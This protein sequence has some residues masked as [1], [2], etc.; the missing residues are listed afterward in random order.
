MSSQRHAPTLSFVIPV[1]NDEAR[2]RRCLESIR[3]DPAFSEL[4]EA[5]VVDNGS[6][7]GSAVMA[8]NMGAMVLTRPGLRVSALRNDGAAAARGEFLA[9]VDADHELLAG[10]IGAVIEDLA[11][12]GVG[13]V[14]AP[15][16]AVR[17]GT[18]VQRMYG[19]LRDH[20][21][22]RF[23]VEWLGSGNLA[24][25]RSAFE[26]IGGFD[27]TLETCEDVDLCLR[28][29][30]SGWRVV[31]DDRLGSVHHG[32]PTSLSALFHAEA[33]RGR[34]NLRVSLRNLTLRGLPSVV[35]P[36]VDLILLILLPVGALL[37]HISGWILSIP[38]LAGII[39]F[40]SIRAA[41][42]LRSPGARGFREVSQALAVATTYDLARSL[43]LVFPS[44]HRRFGP[45]GA[46]K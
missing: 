17:N 18:W 43:A 11:E 34:D 21:P 28:L 19:R 36:A 27:T 40:A 2:L 44:R 13:A 20:A 46:G 45:Q 14:G 39:L 41:R 42:M 32:D 16:L 1:L 33:W 4:A 29:R 24:V 8:R 30:R 26:N 6:T 15:Y 31:S 5:V 12:A 22:G 35:I 25:R 7:D 38:A 3:Q 9:F 23:D 10:W 37:H